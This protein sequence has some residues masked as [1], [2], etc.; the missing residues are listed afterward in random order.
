MQTD[1]QIGPLTKAPTTTHDKEETI[2]GRKS[3]QWFREV[4]NSKYCLKPGQS[5]LEGNLPERDPKAHYSIIIMITD[6]TSGSGPK[7]VK[8]V[9]SEKNM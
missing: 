1:K 7:G 8:C 4:N 2:C 3:L 6:I 5:N 9:T